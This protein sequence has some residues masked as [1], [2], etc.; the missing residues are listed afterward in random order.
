MIDGKCNSYIYKH[1][2]VLAWKLA[3]EVMSP[4]GCIVTIDVRYRA[5]TI[6]F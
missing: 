6:Y 5:A 3:Q 2:M 4:Q 1:I